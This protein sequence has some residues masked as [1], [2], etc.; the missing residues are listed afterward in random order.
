[1]MKIGINAYG[2]FMDF[3][4][5]FPLIIGEV[6]MNSFSMNKFTPLGKAFETDP[7]CEMKVNPEEPPYKVVYQGKTYYFCSE[8]CKI[9]F[10]RMPE[11]YIKGAEE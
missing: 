8:A 4:L 2:N 11:R 3:L 7:V 1:M 5:V 9:L 6:F 10:E